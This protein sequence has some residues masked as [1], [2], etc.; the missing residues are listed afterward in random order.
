MRTSCRYFSIIFECESKEPKN[1]DW[2]TAV[3]NSEVACVIKVTKLMGKMEL[4]RVIPTKTLPTP[5]TGTWC[6]LNLS[7]TLETAKAEIQLNKAKK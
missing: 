2:V 4:E 7:K 1:I 3:C 5:T 6:N